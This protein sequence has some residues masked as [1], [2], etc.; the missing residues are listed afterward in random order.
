[1]TWE[2]DELNKC[3]H[4]LL[5]SVPFSENHPG[6]NRVSLTTTPSYYHY[7]PLSFSV[8]QRT[9]GLPCLAVGA[10]ESG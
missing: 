6:R 3:L 10:G 8:Q 4:R 9:N 5:N 1:M 7:L 2:W